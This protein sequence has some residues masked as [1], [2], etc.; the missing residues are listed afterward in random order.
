MS[1][2]SHASPLSHF[3][4]L[5]WDRGGIRSGFAS[6]FLFYQLKSEVGRIA[7]ARAWLDCKS[8]LLAYL[9]PSFPLH[10][11]QFTENLLIVNSQ[12]NTHISILQE[13]IRRTRLDFDE[14]DEEVR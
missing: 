5:I 6:R 2:A 9:P 13:S 8:Q 3:D 12:V 1:R 7:E 4:V 14:F 10:P 11:R